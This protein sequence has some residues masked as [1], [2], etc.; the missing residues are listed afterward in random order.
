MRVARRV[1]TSWIAI[2]AVLMTALAPAISHAMGARGPVTWTEI[3]TSVGAKRVPVDAEQ[4][5][6][7]SVPGASNLLEHCPYCAL[8]TDGF[9]VPRALAS[10]ASP[11]LVGELLPP[12]FLHADETLSVWSSAQPRAPPISI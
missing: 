3:C 2:L 1:V 10:V 4:S 12:A 8:H 11:A 7:K 6:S 5:G 9:P